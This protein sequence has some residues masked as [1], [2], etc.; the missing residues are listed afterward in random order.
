MTFNND[1]LWGRITKRELSELLSAVH[2]D[3]KTKEEL[4]ESGN[5]KRYEKGADGR[6]AQIC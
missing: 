4:V 1:V 5:E 2:E 6:V 3:G